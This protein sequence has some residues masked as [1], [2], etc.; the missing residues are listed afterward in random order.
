MTTVLSL[1]CV[2]P[3]LKLSSAFL[4]LGNKMPFHLHNDVSRGWTSPSFSPANN[5]EN[6]SLY[7]AAHLFSGNV[8]FLEKPHTRELAIQ[9]PCEA[10][11]FPGVYCK[12]E[13]R[14]E[15]FGKGNVLP[16]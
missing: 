4:F 16:F 14:M 13:E 7:H 12:A 9:T 15:F 8:I 2:L 5:T 3:S 10:Q 6:V 11:R 1:T